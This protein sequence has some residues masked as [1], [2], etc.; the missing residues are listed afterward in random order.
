M[1]Q[2]KGLLTST[3]TELPKTK[4]SPRNKGKT[5]SKLD[6]P[7]DLQEKEMSLAMNDR[8]KNY[9][10]NTRNRMSYNVRCERMIF[11]KENSPTQ[12]RRYLSD[13]YYE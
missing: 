6:Q 3:K 5:K 11:L 9:I 8:N 2:G 13:I 7:I 1:F 12:I 4:F 10:S